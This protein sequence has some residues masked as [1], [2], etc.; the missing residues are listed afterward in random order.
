MIDL[1]ACLAPELD[2]NRVERVRGRLP[3][4][5]PEDWSTLAAIG[6]L[7]L[8]SRRVIGI[9]GGQG[10]GKSTLAAL[11]AEAMTLKGRKAVA[12][13]L[14][15]FYLTRAERMR[16]AGTVHPLLATRGVPGTHDVDLARRTVESLAAGTPTRV[17]RFDKGRDDRMLV[18]TRAPVRDA[19]AVVFEG[20]C[21][22]VAP[23]PGGQLAAPVND[24]EADEDSEGVWRAHVNDACRR[25]APLWAL[26]D[27]WVFL[28]VPDMDC[29]RRWRR[30]QERQL[31]HAERM[32]ERALTRFIAHYERLTL[33]QKSDFPSRADW[34]IRLD[35]RHRVAWAASRV[36][37][38]SDPPF[39]FHSGRRD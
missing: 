15:D 36:R 27:W 35:R 37:S 13:S 33:W 12:C 18:E 39:R 24:L 17:P 8:G 22:G 25:Y 32:S 23:Q 2:A 19:Q 29:V 11:L 21:L 4:G 30:E 34:H 6:A 3:G 5:A 31:P 26:V 1:R 38:G 20:W 16:L 10:S 28:E 14:D 9:C 7:A